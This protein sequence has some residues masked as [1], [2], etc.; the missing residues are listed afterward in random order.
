MVPT[1]KSKYL[2]CYDNK[3]IED[4]LG[5]LMLAELSLLL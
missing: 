4:L 1:L 5:W 2:T 3:V